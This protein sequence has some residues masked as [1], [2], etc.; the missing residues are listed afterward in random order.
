L[1]EQP[2]E[3]KKELID[4]L[5]LFVGEQ[6][7]FCIDI[8]IDGLSCLGAVRRFL[9][10]PLRFDGSQPRFDPLLQSMALC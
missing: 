3:L 6:L 10:I 7:N 2:L 5:L 8:G 1:F 9:S 4:E